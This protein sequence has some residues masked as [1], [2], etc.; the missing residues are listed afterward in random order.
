MLQAADGRVSR[1][2]PHPKTAAKPGSSHLLPH[3]REIPGSILLI[4]KG[5]PTLCRRYSPSKEQYDTAWEDTPDETD[6]DR[7]RPRR[8]A[9]AA[10]A[11]GQPTGPDELHALLIPLC[12]ATDALARLDARAGAA[13]DALREGLIAR[14]AYA[15]AAGCLAHTRAWAHPLDLA[16]RDAGLTASTALA[17]TGAG[18]RSLPQTFSGL[19][20][21]RDWTDPPFEALAD[22]DRSLAEALAL[23]RALRRLAG[24]TGPDAA[25]VTQTLAQLGAEGPDPARFATWWQS[26]VPRPVPRRHRPATYGDR[27]CRAQR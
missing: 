27:G 13:A 11:P 16:L 23:A 3:K 21:P 1:L 19:A 14:L 25:A 8:P 17:A 18:H 9:S 10:R 20:A 22:G 26:A 6:A 15:E 12:A 4:L 2:D 5:S 7:G 24:R